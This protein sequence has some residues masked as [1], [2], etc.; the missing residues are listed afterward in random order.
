[1]NTKTP[2][3]PARPALDE[4]KLENPLGLVF[5][6]PKSEKNLPSATM[7]GTGGEIDHARA[8]RTEETAAPLSAWSISPIAIAQILG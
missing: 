3:S 2:H 5:E 6:T 8:R 4:M 1:M 7:F